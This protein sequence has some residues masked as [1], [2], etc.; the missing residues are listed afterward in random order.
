MQSARGQVEDARRAQEH[1]QQRLAATAQAH[2]AAVTATAQAQPTPAPTSMISRAAGHV[3]HV[4]AEEQ[5]GRLVV[6]LEVAP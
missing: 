6:T 2:H 3:L 4:S 5:D 1:E